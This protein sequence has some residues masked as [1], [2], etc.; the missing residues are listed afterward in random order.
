MLTSYLIRVLLPDEPGSLGKLAGSMGLAQGNIQSVDIVEQFPDGTVMDD[1]VVT[2]PGEYLPDTL[3]S[4]AQADENM[5][6]DSIRP[7]SGRVDRRG[8]VKILANLVKAGAKGASLET[9]AAGISQT[10]TAGWCVILK[11]KPQVTR[12]AATPSAPEDEGSTPTSINVT[13]ARMLY[14]DNEDWIPETWGLLDSSLI[15]T[16]LY[17]TDYVLVIG[18]PGGPEFISSEIEHLDDLGVIIGAI[19]D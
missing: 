3:V 15:A 11:T 9:L 2:L 6:I 17:G 12:A 16:P 13:E 19:L 18:R 4:A 8:Q 14:P 10:M 7:F 5:V 1:I